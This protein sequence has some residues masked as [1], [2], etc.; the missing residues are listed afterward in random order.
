MIHVY[1][2]GV[3]TFNVLTDFTIDKRKH[4]THADPLKFSQLIQSKMI[5][6]QIAISISISIYLWGTTCCLVPVAATIEVA[7]FFLLFFFHFRY[8]IY[9]PT[10][11]QS[12]GKIQTI[13]VH[14][15]NRFRHINETIFRM[16]F[17]CCYF[18][19]TCK[20]CIFHKIVSDI[21]AKICRVYIVD[22][23]IADPFY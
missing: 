15:H 13:P 8:T 4:K 2:S 19:C 20:T 10:C 7:Y 1:S 11:C 17:C 14:R 16:I 22:C 18:Y 9:W 3:C 6:L 5:I 12:C 23:W 21:H